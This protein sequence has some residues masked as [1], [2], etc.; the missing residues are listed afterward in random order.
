MINQRSSIY[1]SSRGERIRKFSGQQ[2]WRENLSC[3]NLVVLSEF[4]S[5]GQMR[6]FESSE[7][8]LKTDSAQEFEILL[9][10]PVV[11]WTPRSTP[12]LDT[13]QMKA[14]IVFVWSRPELMKLPCDIFLI[15][16]PPNGGERVVRIR[17]FG[18]PFGNILRRRLGEMY[19]L[20]RV[21]NRAL[22]WS[23]ASLSKRPA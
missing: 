14:R 8:R 22:R 5:L 4:R 3:R 19:S 6:S 16:L 20:N 10:H 12:A 17:V 9:V 15:S 13:F 1:P 7:S 18:Q 23:T 11:P 21:E 2:I